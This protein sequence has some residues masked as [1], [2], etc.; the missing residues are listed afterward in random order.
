VL[1]DPGRGRNDHTAA[2]CT[3]IRDFRSTVY[4]NVAS[5]TCRVRAVRVR[6]P[7]YIISSALDPRPLVPSV[8]DRGVGS[9][10]TAGEVGRSDGRSPPVDA[11][12]TSRD[13][14]CFVGHEVHGQGSHIARLHEPT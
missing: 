9:C 4:S 14:T 5:D 8:G 7:V 11:E 3:H 10:L 13:G 6:A 2:L 1:G 12:H